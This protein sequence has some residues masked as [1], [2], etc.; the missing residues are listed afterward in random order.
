[1]QGEKVQELPHIALIG[2]DGLGRHP[3]LRAE[4]GEPVADFS[5]DLGGR[6]GKNRLAHIR[7]VPPRTAPLFPDCAEL[8]AGQAEGRT[9]WL[10]P[11]YIKIANL[12]RC[13]LSPPFV[14]ASLT[15]RI[16]FSS[17]QGASSTC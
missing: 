11:G 15:S 6:S 9:R 1:M 12:T 17:W 2:Y 16:D 13:A 8:T 4:M 10:H 14:S 7:V 3:P 5:G